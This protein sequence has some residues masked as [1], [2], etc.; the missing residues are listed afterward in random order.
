L[1]DIEDN[2]GL[3]IRT[4]QT[5]PLQSIQMT[6]TFAFVTDSFYY[7]FVITPKVA[8]VTKR[9]FKGV[10]FYDQSTTMSIDKARTYYKQL[11]A[12]TS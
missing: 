11:Q 2:R 5:V 8:R 9:A 6:K 4:T 3:R 7:E 1:L 10:K 12:A